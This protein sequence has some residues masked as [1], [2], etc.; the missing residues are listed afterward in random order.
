[1][2]TRGARRMSDLSLSVHLPFMVRASR[3]LFVAGALV[4]APLPALAQTV[5]ICAIQG[6]GFIPTMLGSRVSVSG[7][8]TADFQAPQGGF[9]MQE[10]GCDGDAATSDGIFVSTASRPRAVTVGNRVTVTGRVINDRGLTALEMESLSDNGPYAGSLEAVR[11]SPPA[12]AAAAAIYFEAYE[13]ML[14]SLPPSR[15]VAATDHLGAA[16][17]MPDSSGVTRLFRGDADGRKLGLA[18]PASWLMLSQGDLVH[19]VA[20]VLTEDSGQYE[21]DVPPM[22]SLTVERSGLRPPDAVALS[23]STLSVATYDLQGLFDA[24]DDPGKDDEV[25]TADR[26]A[27]GLARRAASIARYLGLP[28]VIGV[29]EAEKVEVLQDLSAQPALLPA[30]YRAVLVEGT[31]PQ[32]LDVGLLYN[33]QRLW[34]R[35]SEARPG[36]MFTRPPLVV[37]LEALDNH[38]RLTAIVNHFQSPTGDTAADEQVRIAQA[39]AVRALVDELKAAEPDVPVVVLGNLNAF[40]DSA[41]LQHLTASGRLVHPTSLAP[42]ERTYTLAAQGLCQIVDHILVD[43]ILAPRVVQLK[44]QHVNVDFGDPGPDAALEASPRA[45]DHDPVLLLLSRP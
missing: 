31:D 14:V 29:Q 3:S 20:G 28:D 23:S 43:A 10:P 21:L 33:S 25:P 9:F 5:H 37:R 39:D 19:D 6:S 40:E 24:L 26:Y 15:V 11:L 42:G 30:S 34:L 22:R 4:L 1:M 8:V 45:S 41:P 13:G 18:A 7:V 44:P 2:K 32:G 12:D 27:A 17:V 35:S 36:A 16:Y 38:E